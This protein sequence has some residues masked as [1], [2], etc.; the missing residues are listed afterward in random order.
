MSFISFILKKTVMAK[1]GVNGGYFEISP[2]KCF[3]SQENQEKKK[4]VA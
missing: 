1:E 2:K 3:E 4:I